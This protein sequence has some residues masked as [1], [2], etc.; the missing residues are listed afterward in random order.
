MIQVRLL[1]LPFSYADGPPF[2]PTR[3]GTEDIGGD[4]PGPQFSMAE[5]RAQCTPSLRS[6]GC[7]VK[8][9]ALYTVLDA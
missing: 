9:G 8:R 5:Y 1:G 2:H 7:G 4:G 6:P 3:Q